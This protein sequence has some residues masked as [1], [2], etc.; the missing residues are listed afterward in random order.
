MVPHSAL[1]TVVIT[2]YNHQSYIRQCVESVLAQRG[3]FRLQLLIGDDLSTDRTR[4]VLAEL[5]RDNSDVINLVFPEIHLGQNGIPLF[6]R[7]MSDARGD[8]IAMLDGDDYWNYPYKLQCQ[9]DYLESHPA[10]AMC[11]HEVEEIHSDGRKSLLTASTGVKRISIESILR[12]CPIGSC[13]PLFRSEV[14][15]PLPSWYGAMSVGD[16]PLYVLAAQSGTID[17]L[18]EVMGAWRVHPAGVW[19]GMDHLER[20]KFMIDFYLAFDKATQRRYHDIL[21]RLSLEQ[22]LATARGQFFDGDVWQAARTLFG[23]ELVRDRYA[24]VLSR[25]G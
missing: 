14:V 15:C 12:S 5:E 20:R 10:C 3:S 9:L 25:F 2:S 13:A 11:F 7:M 21:A 23:N 24:A 6:M 8:F 22:S 18:S 17:F 16:I 4:E 1:V 19:G